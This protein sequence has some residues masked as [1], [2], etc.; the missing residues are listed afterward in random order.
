MNVLDWL[1]VGG[2]P[3]GVHL[4][5]RLVGEG[6]IDSAR[7]A[8]LDPAAQLL[9]RWRSFTSA[10]GMSHLRSPGVH[11]LDL[12]PSSLMRFAGD[13]RKRP[14]GLLR[15]RYN[16]PSLDLFNAHCDHVI[17]RFGLT[18]L[19]LRGKAER[20]QPET[21]GVQ[22][23]TCDGTTIA[24]ARVV[25]ALGA[26]DQPEW[27]EWA[28][29]HGSRIRHLF[30]PPG[31]P[32]PHRSDPGERALV[33]GGG[34]SAVQAAI[35]L[36]AD[37]RT[38][39]LVTR[40][41]PRVHR[42]DSDPG[43][44]GPKLMPTFERERDPDGRRRIIQQARHRGSVTPEVRHALRVALASG[45][46]TLHHSEVS[47]LEVDGAG[48]QLELTSGERI[49]GDHLYLA[50]GF[51][52]RRP[53]GA[54]LDRLVDEHDLR[55]AAC[56]YPIVDSWLRWHPRIHVTGPLAELEIGPVARNIAGARRAGDRLVDA[57]LKQPAA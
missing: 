44:L 2:G 8:I 45:R 17:T 19:H 23:T 32:S 14:P 28:V 50:T 1:I 29:G 20:L 3:H 54:M 57:A 27:P 48:L 9:Q 35:R 34:I 10:T 36:V 52:S 51:A 30:D 16:C 33:V 7:L 18:G 43:W 46:L 55:C 56:G 4:A 41:P 49:D 25:L 39:D 11:H 26:G 37:Q 31:Q 53:G 5:A 24:A 15:S 38:V 6:G 42:F 13:R 47:G 40:H 22:V 21:D 12:E